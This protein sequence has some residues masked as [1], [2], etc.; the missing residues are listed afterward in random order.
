MKEEQVPLCPVS[1]NATFTRFSQDR[2]SKK[3]RE[4]AVA[5]EKWVFHVAS[6]VVARSMTVAIA[7]A[8]YYRTSW[9]H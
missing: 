2:A 7:D 4:C 8:K 5:K 6:S 3:A 9:R 1:S